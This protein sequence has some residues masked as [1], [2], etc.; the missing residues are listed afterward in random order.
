[1]DERTCQL[2]ALAKTALG[3]ERTAFY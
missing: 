1:M 2:I 3:Q